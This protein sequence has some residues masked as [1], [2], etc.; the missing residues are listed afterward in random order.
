MRIRDAV[1]FLRKLKVVLALSSRSARVHSTAEIRRGTLP[2]ISP[3]TLDVVKCPSMGF[4]ND[5]EKKT[6]GGR[7][8]RATTKMNLFDVR[9]ENVRDVAR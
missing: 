7:G 8:I 2:F 3:V 4:L 6:E 9:T 5:R 1:G